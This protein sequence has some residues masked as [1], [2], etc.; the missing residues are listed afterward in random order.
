MKT[1][2]LKNSKLKSIL[3][4]VYEWQKVTETHIITIWN[5]K[6][7]IEERYDQ[8]TIEETVDFDITHCKMQE[9][10]Q[11]EF[12]EQFIKVVKLINLISNQ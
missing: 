9:C 3:A 12:D 8:E 2:Y 6:V 7:E 1:T 5:N 4:E 11:Q 10:T